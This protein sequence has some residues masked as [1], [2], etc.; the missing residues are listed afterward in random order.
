MKTYI[1]LGLII[2]GLVLSI[3]WQQQRI[4]VI[5]S[6]RDSYR[7]T[8]Y[9]L[10]D[11]IDSYR[12]KDSLN[13]VSVGEMQLKLSELNRFRS[14]DI[15]LIETLK[16][17]KKRLQQITTAQTQTTYHLKAPVMD[18]IYIDNY[19][20]DT[21]RCLTIHDKWFDLNGCIDANS[22]FAGRFENRDSLLYVEHIIPKKFW[23]IK[24]GC[25]ERRQEIASRNPHTVITGAE[26]ITVRN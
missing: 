1:Y 13:A 5:K 25:K 16:V 19:I 22:K 17:D 11:N 12:T 23:F 2:A 9:T 18:S 15:K 24:W 8:A 26:Y 4:K 14:N 20:I 3:I 6:D 21:L 7:Q 10:L